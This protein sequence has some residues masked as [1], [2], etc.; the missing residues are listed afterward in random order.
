MWYIRVLKELV[1][2]LLAI[3]IGVLLILVVLDYAAGSDKHDQQQAAQQHLQLKKQLFREG[4][5]RANDQ[6]CVYHQHFCRT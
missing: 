1:V 4:V 2:L 3:V 6:W 5:Y